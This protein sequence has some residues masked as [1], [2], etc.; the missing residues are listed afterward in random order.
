[1]REGG[2]VRQ[3][4]A[5]NL[6][7]RF[8]A[9]HE[10]RVALAQRIEAL[11]GGQAE[12]FTAALGT[13]WEQAA[14]HYSAQ[15]VR[16]R[17]G[18]AAASGAAAEYHSIDVGADDVVRRRIVAVEHLALAAL[19]PGRLG[20]TIDSAGLQRPAAGGGHPHADRAHDGPGQRVGHA[21]MAATAQGLGRVD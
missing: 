6:E 8:E 5:L 14:Q 19:A 1:M 11:G 16:A 18:V 15:V 17:A 13:H 20:C 9:S 21:P 3:R 7:R 12:L 10:Q 2:R 4:T